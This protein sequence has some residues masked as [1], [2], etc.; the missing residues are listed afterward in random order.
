[1]G[2]RGTD[3]GSPR[4]MRARRLAV[5][6]TVAAMVAVVACLGVP[7]GA[8]VADR[9][10]SAAEG[11]GETVHAVA[12][13]SLDAGGS[14][15][16][17]DAAADGQGTTDAGD[18]DLAAAR[19]AYAKATPQASG[20]CYECHANEDLLRASLSDKDDDA[21]KYLV[22]ESFV[23]STHGMLGCTYCHGGHSDE[24]DARAAMAGMNATPTADGGQAVCGRCHQGV[25]D[26][27]KTSLHFNTT[28]IKNA[29]DARL[30]PSEEALGTDLSAQYYHHDGYD[31][32]CIDCHATCGECHVRSA[33]DAIDPDAG[34]TRG[35]NFVDLTDNAD[36][37]YTCLSC[38]AGSIAGCFTDYDVHGPS[39]ANMNCM[40]CHNIGEIHGD[41]TSYQ[42]MSHSGAIT[43]ECTDCHD[44]SSLSGEWHSDTHL[45]KNECWAC[46]TST[47]RTCTSC[48][49][50]AAETRGDVPIEMSEQCFLGYDAADGKITTLAKAP[51]DEGMLGDV[52]DLAL[53]DDLLNTGSTWYPAFTHGVI[54]PQPDQDFCDR[55]HGAGTALLGEDDL[56]YPDW[57][58][59]Q[60]V[61]SLPEVRASDYGGQAAS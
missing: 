35:H 46:H 58:E 60:V 21:S 52:S 5:A 44:A 11:D 43:T 19:E 54:V 34:L 20:T 56:Q 26:T 61:G 28:G 53:D 48:H 59:G 10:A 39:G 45:A 37:T 23:T 51:V 40:D 36:I 55:C 25:V 57:E 1:M 22:D 8:A 14:S 12:M 2:K 32:A 41:G 16:D 30:A 50:W 3:V 47:Y 9:V 4:P 7:R 24:T 33:K 49:G 31:G 42:T 18:D 6:A 27:F 29:W 15:A 13:S 38:H 17:V